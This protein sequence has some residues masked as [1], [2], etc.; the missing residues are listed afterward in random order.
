M[1]EQNVKIVSNILMIFFL[2]SAMGANVLVL[3]PHCYFSLVLA[4]LAT[5]TGI[6]TWVQLISSQVLYLGRYLNRPDRHKR[7]IF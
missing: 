1:M 6:R 7:N 2:S 3:P 5:E 4:L